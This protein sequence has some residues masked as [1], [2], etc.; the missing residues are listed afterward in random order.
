M[1]IYSL[2]EIAAI[3]GVPISHVENHVIARGVA[4]ADH[5]V[6]EPDAIRLIREIAAGRPAVSGS[7]SFFAVVKSRSQRSL[8]GLLTSAGL[9]TLATGILIVY[10]VLL[11]K[12]FR[13]GHFQH[14]E[15]H[16]TTQWPTDD[17]IHAV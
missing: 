11:R 7:P 1:E 10:F 9:H 14:G 5:W 15:H 12:L 13:K 3:A 8:T 2:K 6:A 17:S 16:T 4:A